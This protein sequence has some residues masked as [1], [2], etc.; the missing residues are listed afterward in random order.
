MFYEVDDRFQFAIIRCEVVSNLKNGLKGQEPLNTV[1][2]LPFSN[3]PVF[4]PGESPG[5]KSLA[6][7]Q[8][9]GSQRV[10]QD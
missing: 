8:S 7:L 9:V 10:R 6:G 5:Q 1:L 3:T 2:S 4:L